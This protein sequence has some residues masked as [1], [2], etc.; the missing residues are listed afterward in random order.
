MVLRLPNV[1]ERPQNNNNSSNN[2]NNSNNNSNSGRTRLLDINHGVSRQLIISMIQG[3]LSDLNIDPIPKRV[4][5]DHITF[6]Q[7]E[8]SSISICCLVT[9]H[10]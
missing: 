9:G 5:I 2:N 1:G 8:D 6:T 3:A 10:I 4:V 7:H